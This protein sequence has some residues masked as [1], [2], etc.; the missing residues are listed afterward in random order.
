MRTNARIKV[1]SETTDEYYDDE[2]GE[3]VDGEESSAFFPAYVMDLSIER[4][5]QVFGEYKSGRKCVILR[6][7]INKPYRWIEYKELRYIVSAIRQDGTTLY[8]ERDQ[9]VTH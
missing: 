8:L 5:I 3:W 4:S 2:L 1:V 6:R 9:F 7:P